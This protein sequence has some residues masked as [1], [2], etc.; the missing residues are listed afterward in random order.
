MDHHS[1]AA[2]HANQIEEI[3]SKSG[4]RTNIA[5]STSIDTAIKAMESGLFPKLMP[6]RAA[7]SVLKKAIEARQAETA[8]SNRWHISCL[9][10]SLA[11]LRL[12]GIKYSELRPN[13]AAAKETIFSRLP[14]LKA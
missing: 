12:L 5:W 2:F 1:A 11:S 7:V 4:G 8:A 14:R 9:V 6:K 13:Y 10:E 3:L